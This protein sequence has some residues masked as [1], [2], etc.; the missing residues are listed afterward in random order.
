[1]SESDI[2]IIRKKHESRGLSMATSTDFR[3][4]IEDGS[5]WLYSAVPIIHVR[6]ALF[7]I[8]Y[9]LFYMYCKVFSSVLFCI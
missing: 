9:S 3:N 6:V 1:M 5:L 4:A 8:G 7:C 2:D